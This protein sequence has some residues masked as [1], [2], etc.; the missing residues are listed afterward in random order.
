MTHIPLSLKVDEEADAGYIELPG[1]DQSIPL[2]VQIVIED[3]RL[4][5][6]IILDVNDDSRVVGIEIVGVSTV[7]R[8][9]E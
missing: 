6:E 3:E 1:H 7:L 5:G 2:R 9:A 4:A 8:L